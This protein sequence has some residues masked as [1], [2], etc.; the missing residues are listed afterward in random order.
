MEIAILAV[1]VLLL[2]A[3]VFLILRKPASSGTD[4]SEAARA[5]AQS[6]SLRQQ[7]EVASQERNRFQ[8]N[9]QALLR[10]K[11]QLEERER[12]AL[13]AK[14]EALQLAVHAENKSKAIEEAHRAALSQKDTVTLELEHN[15]K[16]LETK[17]Q[18]YQKS[19]ENVQTL[20]D[21]NNTLIEANAELKGKNESLSKQM[22]ERTDEIQK[23]RTELQEQFKYSINELMDVKARALKEDNN[24]SVS[25]LLNP[26]KE[27]LL[28]FSTRVE[29]LNKQSAEQ[30]GSLKAELGNIQQLNQ[31]L[32]KEAHNLA[33]ALR[34]NAKVMGDWG[35][36]TLERVLQAA[37]LSENMYTKQDVMPARDGDEGVLRSD[38]LIRLPDERYIVVDSKVSINAYS[39]YFHATT[40]EA[41]D[42]AA[43]AL[44]RSIEAHINK[45]AQSEYHNRV[46]SP[47]FTFMFMPYDPIFSVAVH[48]D[49]NIV[50]R[51]YQRRVMLVTPS[52]LVVAL[53]VVTELWQRDIAAKSHQELIRL[54]GVIYQKIHDG[55]V[56]LQKVGDSL[57]SAQNSYEKSLGQLTVGNG[58]LMVTAEKMK[59]LGGQ[60]VKVTKNLK[61][62]LPDVYAIAMDMSDANEDVEEDIEAGVESLNQANEGQ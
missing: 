39:D 33:E 58:N 31:A 17:V 52:T 57:K 61:S 42:Q 27:R 15:T 40:K 56:N 19:V 36:I 26:V 10:E 20:R 8:E 18:D 38:F 45:L 13:E 44:L 50:A 25:E 37:G 5:Q 51:A 16:L 24:T 46:N 54:A 28:E 9:N 41:Q 2:A 53:K 59:S 1:L 29:D 62:S 11:T 35:E 30:H 32:S 55:L 14:A 12:V 7:L 4:T 3:I 49:P 34:G 60:R 47:E 43:K 23:V 22:Q 48:E 21:A 6:E